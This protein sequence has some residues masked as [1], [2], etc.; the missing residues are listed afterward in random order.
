MPVLSNTIASM[1]LS[2]SRMPPFLIRIPFL[3]ARAMVAKTA[4]GA[5][6]LM[7]V[8]KSALIMAIIAAGPTTARPTNPMPRVGITIPSANRSL[9]SH[10]REEVEAR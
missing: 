3:A 10:T 4:S 8:P 9:I 1:L 7:P 2:D 5:A 6:T